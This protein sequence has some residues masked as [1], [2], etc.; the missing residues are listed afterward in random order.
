MSTS[1]TLLIAGCGDVGSRLARQ[2]LAANW[3]VYGLRRDISRLPAGVMPI[4]ADLH[5]DGCP[6][7]W[8]QG[9][10]DYLVYCLAASDSGE[11]GYRAAYVDGLRHVLHWLSEHG[12]RPKRVLF[13]SSTR[14]YGQATGEWVDETSA[15]EP[16]GF[17]GRIML[18]AE[19]L[20]LN[21][22][23]PASVVRLTGIYGPGRQWLLN[24]VRQGYRVVSEPP[25]Y[26]NRI[27]AD[28]AAGLLALLLQADVR[29]Q[30]LQD[31]YIGVDDEPAALHEVVAWLRE[32]LAVTEWSA[33]STVR[34][35]GS[36]RCRNARARALGWVPQY[37]SYR[38]GYA[39]LLAAEKP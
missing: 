8:P 31:C 37:L 5:R 35:A 15:T 27:H 34:R 16:S 17:S 25:L 3:T 36:K 22:G 33:E 6:P 32:Q 26:G 13:V 14:V 11:A 39:A 38:Q 2:M 18:E 9:E 12:Q 4:A 19:Q 28:D 23:L 10:L 21:C 20:L 24:Q 29:G 7:A 30:V 1:P